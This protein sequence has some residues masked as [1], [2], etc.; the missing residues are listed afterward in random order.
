MAE[1]TSAPPRVVLV[2]G[3]STFLGGYLVAR[4]AANPEIERVLAVDSRVPRKDLLRRM[5]RAEFLRLDIRRPTI[6][7]ALASYKVDTVVHAATSIADTAPHSAAIKEFNVVG[8]MQVCAACQRTPSVKR[9]V[10]RSTGMVYG[11]SSH[12]PSHF[13]EETRA[14][15]EPTR[16]YG[17]DL[18]DVEGYVR[19]LGRRRQDIDITIVRPQA[20]LGP[21]IT[22]RISS[23][24]AAPVVPTVLGYQPRLQFLHEE[25]ALAAMEYVTLAGKVGTFNISGEGVV[26]LTQAIRRVGHV[27]LPV[28][29]G[30]LAPIAGVF[31]DL[32]SAKLRSSQTEFL[33]YGRVLDTTRMRTELGFVPRYTTLETL[34][35]FVERSGV[36]PVIGADA[37]RSLE[38]RVVS[39]AHQL[40]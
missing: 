34:D 25:D 32:R 40:Q 23:Y 36:T 11:A 30:L 16:G 3:A 21:R 28:P 13:A 26:T 37:W 2:T 12:D 6:A 14:R 27:E 18:L 39:A 15:R 5:G 19:G 8:A 22:T 24:L 20:M 9:L 33:T 31:Q 1:P 35:D 4:L 7:K 29:S 17:R 38:R 10:L